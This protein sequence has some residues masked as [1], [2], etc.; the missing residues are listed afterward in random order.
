[1]DVVTVLLALGQASASVMLGG[2]AVTVAQVTTKKQPIKTLCS[3]LN[4]SA[5]NHMSF[6][7]QMSMNAQPTMEPVNITAS[8]PMAAITV[9]VTMGTLWIPMG[10]G[11]LVRKSARQVDAYMVLRQD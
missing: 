4:Y 7:C 2:W 8:T 6:L 3:F 9:L 5:V 10:K 1:M 11:A